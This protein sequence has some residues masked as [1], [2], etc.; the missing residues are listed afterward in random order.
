MSVRTIMVFLYKAQSVQVGDK[1][2][3]KKSKAS[4]IVIYAGPMMVSHICGCA[5]TSRFGR[6]NQGLVHVE[7]GGE[8]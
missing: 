4:C 5:R 3:D 1:K 8:P 6:E 7:L 2:E